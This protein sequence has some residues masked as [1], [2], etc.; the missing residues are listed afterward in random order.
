MDLWLQLSM[1][2]VTALMCNEI[3]AAFSLHYKSSMKIEHL[4]TVEGQDTILVIFFVHHAH[5]AQSIHN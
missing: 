2:E 5:N 1:C 3:E 4:H